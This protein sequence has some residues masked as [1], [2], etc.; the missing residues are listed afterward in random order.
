MLPSLR[1]LLGLF[2][3]NKW[4]Q[5]ASVFPVRVQLAESARYVQQ[6]TN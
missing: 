2:P 6:L 5:S 4:A 3:G 1:G